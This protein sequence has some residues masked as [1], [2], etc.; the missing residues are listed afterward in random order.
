[1]L[2][3]N[4]GCP[5]GSPFPLT[6][7]TQKQPTQSS[8]FAVRLIEGGP[9]S[10]LPQVPAP[11]VVHYIFGAFGCLRKRK[12]TNELPQRLHSKEARAS[13]SCKHRIVFGHH[14]AVIPAQRL[15]A[16]FAVTRRLLFCRTPRTIPN[17]TAGNLLS[18]TQFA[19]RA[20]AAST[21]VSQTQPR[22]SHTSFICDAVA[23]ASTSRIRRSRGKLLVWRRIFAQDYH[24]SFRASAS[25][26]ELEP[27]GGNFFPQIPEH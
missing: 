26:R 10:I 14:G 1:M 8:H 13:A 5:A 6:V 18:S 15:P 25:T 3:R 16:I 23:T 24:F 7:R 11:T 17:L 21:S 22:G 19:V 2:R 4:P 20:I 12:P 9:I 27:S